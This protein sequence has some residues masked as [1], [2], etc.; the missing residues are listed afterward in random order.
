MAIERMKAFTLLMPANR[1][2]ELLKQLQR[3]EMVHFRDLG[4][5]EGEGLTR[6]PLDIDATRIDERISKLSYLIN[7]VKPPERPK[8]LKGMMTPQRA[9]D[10]DTFDRYID[11]EFQSV[12]DTV[13]EIQAEIAAKKAEIARLSGENEQLSPWRKLDVCKQDLG[14]RTAS[15][16]L[17][18]VQTSGLAV[19]REAVETQVPTAFIEV[20]GAGRSDTAFALLCHRSTEE[21]I[22]RISK[23]S[24]VSSVNMFEKLPEKTIAANNERIKTLTD[25]INTL[26]DSFA[27]FTAQYDDFVIAR[28]CAQT[29]LARANANERFLAT[30]N[31]VWLAG[32][33]PAVRHDE[34]EKAV[35]TACGD[36]YYL[37][38]LDV[39]KDDN[40]VP[41][42]LKN[43]RVFEAFEDITAM[44]SM[45]HYNEIDPTPVLAPFYW[46]FFGLMVGDMGYGLILIAATAFALRFL[47]FKPGMRRMI[48]FFF[49]LGFGVILGGAAY[50]SFFGYTVF[51][52]IQAA[53]GTFKAILDS[54]L[55][56][57]TMLIFS[58][59][60]GAAQIIF[61]LLVKGYMLIRDGKFIDALFDAGFW[62]V[63]II[64]GLGMLV[65][66]T[67]MLPESISGAVGWVFLAGV[68]G[69]AA[70]QGRSSKSI[71]GKLAQGLYAVYGLSGYVGDLVS[72][73]RITA[74]ALS[75]AYIAFSFNLMATLLPAGIIRIIGGAIIFLLGQT[76]N[77]GL[78]CLG[79]YVH[80]CRLQYVEYFSKFYE[81]GGVQYKPL[82]YKN[83][84]VEIK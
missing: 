78:S 21:E 80:S 24:G 65:S 58:V 12:Y 40:D 74:L 38:T 67:G 29:A 62:L 57:V 61:A 82:D 81:G 46:L 17:G 47:H 48:R 14:A 3:L 19:F 56:I 20:L 44:Y 35:R 59:A 16:M 31:T 23:A 45:P 9:L 28:E 25:E 84:A 55:D 41:I 66:T 83:S 5:D 1:R 52:P 18:T 2:K 11:F 43:N 7:N 53:D 37:E 33:Y 54:Q 36:S 13:N 42:K 71:G 68:I 72:Y 30:G 4:K 76:L 60:L 39:E 63:T 75:G 69:L 77:L 8:G 6:L 26:G 34:F 73:T 27:G 15:V 32:W 50:G 10:Y 49:I 22:T 79:A 64:G 51:T 70:T